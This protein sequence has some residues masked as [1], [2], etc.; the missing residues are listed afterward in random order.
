MK[1]KQLKSYSIK[2]RVT[3]SVIVMSSLFILISLLFSYQTSHHEI[4]EVYDAR[5]GQTAK[6]FLLRMPA[7]EQHMSDI[8]SKKRLEKW[9]R[10]IQIS[11]HSESD[12]T[13][14]G[15]P[16]EQN[17]VIQF[18]HHGRLLWSSHPD[19]HEIEH[20]PSFSGFGYVDI[21]G[22]EWRYFELPMSE[23]QKNEYIIV[24]E[25][26]SVRDE[27]MNELALSTLIPQLALIPC[28]AFLMFFLIER[29]FAPVTELKKAIGKR[30]VSKLDKIVV[31]RPTDELSALVNALNRLL[32]EL[33]RAWKREKRFTRMAAHELKTPLAILRLNAENALICDKEEDL[34]SDLKNI[35]QGIE[36]S[37]RLI[38]QLLTLA[39]VENLHE[40]ALKDVDLKKLMQRV[41]GELAPLA[42]KN[43]QEMSFRGDDCIIRGDESLLGI[44]LSNLVDNAIR[45]SGQGSQIMARIEDDPEQVRIFIADTGQDVSPEAREKLFDSFYRS[46][47]EKGDGAGL[48]LSITR[49]IV[50]LHQGS[51]V[52]LPRA[53][54]LN[55]FVVSLAKKPDVAPAIS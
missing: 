25:R 43:Q 42:L 54:E 35:L 21:A 50:R 29:N 20:D 26:Q 51:V 10:D 13:A 11:S 23:H 49:D 3:F 41:M 15:H 6:L 19:F 18:Y 9:M 37:D 8:E 32:S 16:Y 52:L 39:R 28:L 24:A 30:S 47:R 17:L 27:M 36:R 2:K 14:Y 53:N 22:E 5:L 48:G 34:K 7:P 45:Y 4:L 33:E 38:Q 31:S 1:N 12:E 55:T 40:I 44:L 46:N